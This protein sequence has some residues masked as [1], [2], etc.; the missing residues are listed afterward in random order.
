MYD[1]VILSAVRDV[2]PVVGSGRRGATSAEGSIGARWM[3]E[4]AAGETAAWVNNTVC[5]TRA[6]VY[7]REEEVEEVKTSAR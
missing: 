6:R 3:N 2:I 5:G 7:A 1:D 4:R